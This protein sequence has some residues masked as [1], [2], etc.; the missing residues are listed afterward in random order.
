MIG[1]EMSVKVRPAPTYPKP[2]GSLSY[3]VELERDSSEALQRPVS[4]P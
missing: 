1:E 4:A 2:M 3:T